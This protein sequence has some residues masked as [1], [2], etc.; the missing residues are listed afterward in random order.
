[1]VF[2]HFRYSFSSS[3]SISFSFAVNICS[4]ERKAGRKLSRIN[5]A[6]RNSNA[7]PGHYFSPNAIKVTL[8]VIKSIEDLSKDENTIYKNLSHTGRSSSEISEAA[9]FGKNKTLNILHTLIQKGYA[10][11]TGNGRGTKYRVK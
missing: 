2:L 1:M 4:R 5:A 9:G 10:A 8:P 6:Y 3:D 7:K 11:Q